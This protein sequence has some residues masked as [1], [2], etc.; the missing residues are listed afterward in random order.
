MTRPGLNASSPVLF[1]SINN[2]DELDFSY[3]VPTLSGLS[4]RICLYPLTTFSA[5]PLPS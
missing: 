5:N 2:A 3:L 1:F 4:V